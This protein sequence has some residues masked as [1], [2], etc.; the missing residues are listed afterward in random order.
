[1]ER[2]DFSKIAAIALAVIW[3]QEV[4]R[5]GYVEGVAMQFQSLAFDN[6]EILLHAEV[7]RSVAWAVDLVPSERSHARVDGASGSIGCRRKG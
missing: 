5:V 1:M 4:W 3:L 6:L 7:V 2:L